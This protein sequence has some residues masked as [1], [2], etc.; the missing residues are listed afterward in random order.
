MRILISGL[1]VAG[2]T[3]AYWLSRHGFEPVIVE[4]APR[5]RVG[6]Y[7]VDFWG[8]GYEVA[9]RMGLLPQLE[10][11]GYF[12]REVRLVDGSGRRVG[13][14][15]A[16]VFRRATDGRFVSLP[17]GELSAAIHG[18]IDGKVEILFGDSITGLDERDGGVT[19]RFARSSPV[20]EFDLV[21]GADGLHSQVRRLRF[22][23]EETF[24]VPLGY[25]VGAFEAQGYAPRD[26]D[27]YVSYSEPGRQVAR[28]ALRGDRTLFLFVFHDPS[29]ELPREDDTDAQ[30]AVLHRQFG[31]SGWECPRI[32]AALDACDELYFDRVSQIRMESW[33]QGRVALVGDAA[34]CPSLL[35]GEGSALAMIG[36]YVLAGELRRAEGDWRAAFAE[37]ERRLG[38]FV[39]EK[40][41]AAARFAT[42]FAPRT[43]FGVAVRNLVTHAFAVG[44]IADLFLGKALRD[45]IHLPDY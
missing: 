38:S 29:P 18:A 11:R 37:Y 34:W 6:G 9:E 26:E 36:A 27:V 2:P 30:K 23:A 33:T 41:R 25:K 15:F 5:L 13:G 7:I 42:S 28:F 40:Q 43:A 17:R 21:V 16:D 31:S 44:P 14:F 24:E 4:Q 20:R 1:G 35:A 10:A 22:G 39:S 8:K 32:L 3:L 45:E 12:V 19:V